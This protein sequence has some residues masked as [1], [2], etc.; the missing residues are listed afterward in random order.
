LGSEGE[1][2]LGALRR[3]RTHPLRQLGFELADLTSQVRFDTGPLPAFRSTR[4]GETTEQLTGAGHPTRFETAGDATPLLTVLGDQ[5]LLL[6]F[7]L[8][9]VEAPHTVHIGACLRLLKAESGQVGEPFGAGRK[10]TS[11]RRRI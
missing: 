11:Y 6:A 2:L 8:R 4:L 1:F 10:G 3:E 9:L 5:I 7:R